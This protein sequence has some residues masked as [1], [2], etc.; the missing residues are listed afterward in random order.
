MIYLAALALAGFAAGCKD[1][2]ESVVTLTFRKFLF[3]AVIGIFPWPQAAISQA[4]I[5][6]AASQGPAK[7]SL[8][9]RPLRFEVV[10]IRPNKSGGPSALQ[11]LSNGY[12]AINISLGLSIKMAY[13]PQDLWLSEPVQGEPAW[14]RTEMYDITAKIAPSDMEEWQKQGNNQNKMLESMLQTALAE[15]CKLLVHHI[16]REAAAWALVADKKGPKFKVSKPDEMVNGQLVP[17][18]G[19]MIGYQK[20]EKPQVKFFGYSM[21]QFA[22]WLSHSSP[23]R[24]VLNK[25]SLTGNFDFVASQIDLSSSPKD[26][27]GAVSLNNSDPSNIWDLKALGLTLMPV[28]TPM[29]TL[30]IDHIERPS[31]N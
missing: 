19:K 24:P 15:R 20:G 12:R 31:E 23:M 6:G 25:T 5:A 1:A 26:R 29:E 13:L 11:I 7:N 16:P 14:F 8:T 4:G 17:N 22:A 28:T 21:D 3:L 18:E 9:T 30:V 27:G 10:S 2:P